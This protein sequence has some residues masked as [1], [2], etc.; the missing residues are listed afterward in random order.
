[1]SGPKGGAEMIR[2]PDA[3]RLSSYHDAVCAA[4]EHAV[5]LS[6]EELTTPALVLDLDV[7]RRNVER[8]AKSLAAG[9]VKLRPH[10]KVHKSPDAAR[11][12][13]AGGAIGVATATV[14]EAAVMLQCGIQDVLIANQVVG[15][16]KVREAAQLAGMGSLM[17]AVDGA[18]NIVH[19]GTAAR[20]EGTQLGV[21]IEYDIGMGRS[22]ARS[23]GELRRLARAVEA[24]P[25]L[26]LRGLMGYEGHCM[27]IFD[28]DE[29][30]AEAER[31]MARL[32]EAA[33]AL[34]EEGHTCNVISGGGTGT[35]FISGVKPPLTE[36][37]AGTY[38]V[39]D[40]FHARLVPEFETALKVIGTVISRHGPVAVL[41]AGRKAVSSDLQAPE[42]LRH[43]VSISFVHEEHMGLTVAEGNLLR[44]GDKV[45][46]R[47][48]Y[49]PMTV[50]LYD[51]Y[52]VVEGGVVTRIW[53]IFAR[54][55]GRGQTCLL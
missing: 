51:A 34:E 53:P 10:I 50:N 23:I 47:P 5:G 43:G 33:E 13:L 42:L 2:W 39:M 26:V 1:M 52:H 46:I 6:P 17:I 22:G 38:M 9:P 40:G 37:Q 31:A 29:R 35:Y 25:G 27:S 28:R 55:P 12:Q 48:G 24:A 14:W 8:M 3:D 45:A 19:L 30:V 54:Q 18:E 41:D 20:A 21:L 4:Y 16:E 15:E 44:V 7:A 49:G 11:V 36:T 32:A